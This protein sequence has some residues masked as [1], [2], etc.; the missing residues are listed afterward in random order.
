MSMAGQYATAVATG[1][2]SPGTA[3][4]VAAFVRA[5]LESLPDH[6]YLIVSC[7]G[8][9]PPGAPTANIRALIEMARRFV[10]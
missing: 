3:A 6:S 4:E 7:A 5:Q 2:V 8:G 1:W 9:I 10:P